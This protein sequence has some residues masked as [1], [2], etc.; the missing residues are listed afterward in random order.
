MKSLAVLISNAGTGTNLQGIIDAIKNKKLNSKVEVVISSD[1][2]A[3][4]LTRAKENNIACEVCPDKK[5][6]LKILQKYNPDYIC[7]TGW[8]LII[9]DDVIKVY[10]NKILNVHPGLIPDRSNGT[11]LNPDGSKGIWNKGKL[12]D[13]AIESFLNNNATYAGS[14]IHFLSDEFDFGKV[15]GRCFEKIN[16]DDSV[17]SLYERLKKKENALYVNV[18]KKLCN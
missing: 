4:G 2:D 17:D 1:K 12:T 13:V 14:S 5:L 9:T 8:K 10:K 7:L 11:V 18:L 15:M 3:Y 6:L 16:N